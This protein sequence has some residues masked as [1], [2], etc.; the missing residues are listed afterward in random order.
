MGKS[1]DSMPQPA[2]KDTVVT[3]Y[4]AERDPVRKPYGGAPTGNVTAEDPLMP[5]GM[6]KVP[7]TLGPESCTVVCPACYQTIQTDVEVKTTSEPNVL[8]ILCDLLSIGEPKDSMPQPAPHVAAP[9]DH[10]SAGYPAQHGAP[11]ANVPGVYTT[12]PGGMVALPLTLGPQPC[13]VVCPACHQTIQTA[14]QTKATTKTHLMA[15]LLLV[16]GFFP[17]FRCC[18]IPYCVDSCQGKHHY[19][20]NCKAFIGAY[21]R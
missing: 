19:C 11:T 21:D 10:K 18:C 8:S 1:E 5:G 2:P 20:P 13:N 7:L 4:D 9:V 15:L 6:M 12:R 16:V 3:G 17:C 14:V